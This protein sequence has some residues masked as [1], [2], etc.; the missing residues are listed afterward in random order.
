[1]KLNRKTLTFFAIGASFFLVQCNLPIFGNKNSDINNGPAAIYTAAAQTVVARVTEQAASEVTP[2]SITNTNGVTITIIPTT[3]AVY[4]T[5]LA[6]L[7]PT[8]PALP[9]DTPFSLPPTGPQYPTA[10][11]LPG[12]PVNPP[13]NPPQ[14]YPPNY[15]PVNPPPN[16]PPVYYPTVVVPIPVPVVGTCD[17]ANFIRDINV[18]D[19]TRVV[20]GTPFT[21]IWRLRNAGTCTWDPS[22][23]I[24]FASGYMLGE[25]TIIPFTELVRPGQVIDVAM[26]L[27]APPTAGHYRA[28]FLIR[29]SYGQVFGLGTNGEKGF[30]VDIFAIPAPTATAT[31]IPPSATPQPSSTPQ[32]S[33]TPQP[34]ATNTATPTFTL[35]PSPTSAPPTAAPITSVTIAVIGP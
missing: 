20:V 4:P 27:K 2:T 9:S 18:R 34:T 14:N 17:A 26:N 29:N 8:Y 21:K 28:N 19:G 35:T 11:P 10:I 15:P 1:M 31:R 33:A 7:E 25:S 23:A 22:Y 3:T 16:Y 6:T 24:V 5:A 13:V 30:W 32:P 12:G